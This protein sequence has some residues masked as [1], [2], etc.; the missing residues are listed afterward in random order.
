MFISKYI[1]EETLSD[2]GRICILL[3]YAIMVGLALIGALQVK[4]NF[5]LE[6]FMV[7]DKPVTKFVEMNALYFNEGS[8]LAILSMV[9]DIDVS[10]LES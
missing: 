1:A 8:D 4:S 9:D 5:S 10:S 7:P 2:Q 6:F 3:L